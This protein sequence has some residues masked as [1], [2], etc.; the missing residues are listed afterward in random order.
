MS[1]IGIDMPVE[2]QVY[3]RYASRAPDSVMM[4]KLKVDRSNHTN[5]RLSYAT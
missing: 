4:G 1:L 2:Q 3:Y 5:R